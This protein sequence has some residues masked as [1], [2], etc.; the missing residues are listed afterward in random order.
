M[1][2]EDLPAGLRLARNADETLNLICQF[3]ERSSTIEFEGCTLAEQRFDV[4]NMVADQGLLCLCLTVRIVRPGRDPLEKDV[5][6]CAEED[7][8]SKPIVEAVLILN[9]S[10]DDHGSIRGQKRGHARFIPS[11][12]GAHPAVV[13][14]VD[15]LVA[16][17]RHFE[18]EGALSCP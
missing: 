15:R 16:P 13:V 2:A 17:P 6:W 18:E 1:H 7:D 9:S 8:G 14:G 11:A 4:G 10:R 12:V 5:H 3:R